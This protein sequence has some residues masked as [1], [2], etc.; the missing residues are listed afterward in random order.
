PPFV[1]FVQL[2]DR[3]FI[4]TKG[5]FISSLSPQALLNH[6]PSEWFY[7]TKNR[8]VPKARGGL[9]LYGISW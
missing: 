2:A 8:P 9:H 7:A 4:I 6:S 5:V 1:I 3:T